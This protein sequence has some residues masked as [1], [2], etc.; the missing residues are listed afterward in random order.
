MVHSSSP[1]LVQM[2]VE[3][4]MNLLDFSSWGIEGVLEMS[5]RAICC[6]HFAFWVLWGCFSSGE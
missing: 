3:S 1:R 5:D 6:L 4:F 2:T